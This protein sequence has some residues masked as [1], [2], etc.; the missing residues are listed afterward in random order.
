MDNNLEWLNAQIPAE[1]KQRVLVMAGRLTAE[2]GERISMSEV[3]RRALE[4]YL[5]KHEE[6]QS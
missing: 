2:T 4:E 5:A 6:A 3:V 1:L